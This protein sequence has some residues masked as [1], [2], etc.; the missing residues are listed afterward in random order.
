MNIGANVGRMECA[1]PRAQDDAQ[2]FHHRSAPGPRG[3]NQIP[4]TPALSPREREN[5]RQPVGETQPLDISATALNAS[6]ALRERVGV[7]GIGFFGRGPLGEN[8]A[9]TLGSSADLS[10]AHGAAA[11]DGGA[12]GFTL[13]ELLVVISIIGLL[14]ALAVPVLNNFKPNYTASATAQ[15]MDGIARARQLAIAQHTT[16]FMVFVPTNFWNDAAYSALPKSEKD[17]A[18]KL[19][20]KQLIGYNF[21][22]LRSLGDQPGQPT[23]RYLGP[24]RSLPEGAFITFQKFAYGNATWFPI[25]T[26]DPSG[27][28]FLGFQVY[29]FDRTAQV[30]FP[31]EFAPAASAKQ[32]YVQLPYIAFDYMGREVRFDS[33][34]NP[35]PP[36]DVAIP[37]SKGSVNFSR[38]LN[39]VATQNPPSIY[40]SPA[41]NG[42]NS[43]SY[44]VVYIDWL[45]GR[46]RVIR[47]EVR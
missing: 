8:R 10:R 4:L 47:Q 40:E 39:R 44:N 22:S 18:A 38:G 20:D 9:A 3:R 26:N 16:V 37:L 36:R 41:G 6:L 14:A 19:F 29:G 45:T 28:S 30:P 21:V 25:Y 23:V 33:F 32:P 24:W 17:K 2:G 13:I 27:G 43:V 34:G 42:T 5:L 7:R 46:A 35:A 31:S 1:R 12:P 15:L 11:E